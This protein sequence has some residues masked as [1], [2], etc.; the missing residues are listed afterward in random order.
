MDPS[1]TTA[2]LIATGVIGGDS[3][4]GSLPAEHLTSLALYL[5]PVLVTSLLSLIF[6][7]KLIKIKNFNKYF[8]A[9][10]MLLV[11]GAFIF[12]ITVLK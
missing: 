5:F 12:D 11:L 8:F 6:I 4:G 2:I 9:F 3:S 7:D 10:Q 1:S